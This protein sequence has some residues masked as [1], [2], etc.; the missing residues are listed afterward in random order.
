MNGDGC[1][2]KCAVE[3][4]YQCFNGSVNSSSVCLISDGFSLTVKYVRRV[5]T[6]NIM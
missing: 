4:H 6:G 2:A 1:S 5:L 3:D